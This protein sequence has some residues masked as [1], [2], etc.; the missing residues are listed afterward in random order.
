MDVDSVNPKGQMFIIAG[1][2]LIMMLFSL[3][4][5]LSIYNTGQEKVNLESV[6]IQLTAE[7]LMREYKNIAGL[8]TVKEN[9]NA[10]AMAYFSNFSDLVRHDADAKILYSFA[11]SNGTSQKFW[12]ITGNYLD[13]SINLT[14][15]ATDSTP[16]SV[17]IGVIQ[18][19]TNVTRE[20]SR[21]TNVP[22][23][24]TLNYTDSTGSRAERFVLNA[25]SLNSA[26]A[27]FDIRIETPEGF[28]RIKETYNRSW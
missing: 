21:T 13:D 17:F 15:Y 28:A 8:A 14:I 26:A 11:F 27:L 20:F 1:I 16:S 4:A 10:S 12:V 3:S 22:I 6:A 19:K 2:I 5:L 25:S 23:N 9:V 7:N 18:D 24:I